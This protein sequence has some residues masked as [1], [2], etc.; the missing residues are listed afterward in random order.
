[1]EICDVPHQPSYRIFSGKV[2]FLGKE[3]DS[4]KAGI[5]QGDTREFKKLQMVWG[6][7]GGVG[8]GRWF[9]AKMVRLE[10]DCR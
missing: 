7:G 4:T 5:L 3:M 9:R 2:Q 10:D 1:M 6:G 8:A